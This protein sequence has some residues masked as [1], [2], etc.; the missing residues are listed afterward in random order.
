MSDPIK[1][2]RVD[3][4]I[5]LHSQINRKTERRSSQNRVECF[6]NYLLSSR[7][8]LMMS[9]SVCLETENIRVSEHEL[10]EATMRL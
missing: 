6:S 5:A 1:I 2:L 8:C 7:P 4:F 10:I 3:R 9:R